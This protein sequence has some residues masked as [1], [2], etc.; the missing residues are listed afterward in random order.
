MMCHVRW[1]VCK[2]C[3]MHVEFSTCNS[4]T[5][6]DQLQQ[7]AVVTPWKASRAGFLSLILL[8]KMG[9]TWLCVNTL[10]DVRPHMH[11]LAQLSHEQC[12]ALRRPVRAQISPMFPG[13]LV[14]PA[15][16]KT[17][18]G[19]PLLTAWWRW[20]SYLSSCVCPCLGMWWSCWCSRGSLS[21]FTWPTAS[22]STSS[23][24]TYSRPY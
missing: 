18:S 11:T 12:Q 8:I 13:C 20:C 7:L 2:W 1:D 24:Q 14:S 21:S 10:L 4:L 3:G 22:S 23:W 17:R 9:L 5:E 15:R 16:V 19:P 6:E